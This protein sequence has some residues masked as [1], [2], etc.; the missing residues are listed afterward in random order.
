MYGTIHLYI[1]G[2]SVPHESPGGFIPEVTTK[3][4]R[5][6]APSSVQRAYDFLLLN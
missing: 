6:V 3:V 2:Y 5:E 1:C 4:C